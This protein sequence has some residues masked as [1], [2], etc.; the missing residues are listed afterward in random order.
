MYYHDDPTNFGGHKGYRVAIRLSNILKK[1]SEHDPS[2][3][4][5]EVMVYV[6]L[7]RC[8]PQWEGRAV[9]IL[10]GDKPCRCMCVSDIHVGTPP[11]VEITGGPG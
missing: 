6:S 10:A 2:V 1:V 8:C 4:A 9:S 11:F 5:E 7:K 3:P